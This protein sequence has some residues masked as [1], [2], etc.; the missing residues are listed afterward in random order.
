MRTHLKSKGLWIIVANGFEER[1]N[2]GELTTAEMKNLEVKYSQD[3]K[4][5][6]KIQMD[7]Q[8]HILQNLLLLRL[9]IKI[10]SLSKSKCMVIKRHALLIFKLFE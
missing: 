9:L 2:D 1:N 4:A 5:L 3:A 6:S 10:G 7:S 8:E